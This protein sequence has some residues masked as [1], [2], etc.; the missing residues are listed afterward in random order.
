MDDLATFVGGSMSDADRSSGA[1]ASNRLGRDEFAALFQNAYGRLWLIA[2]AIVGDRSG[3]DD[4]VQESALAA[5]EKLQHFQPGTNF[6]A[7]LAR[8]VRW[9]AFNHAR[10]QAGRNTHP[11]DPHQLDLSLVDGRAEPVDLESDAAGHIPEYQTH[12]DDEVVNALRAIGETGRACILLRT[13]HQLSYRE[14]AELLEIPE[15][16]AMSHVH[17]ARQSMRDRLKNYMVTQPRSSP[18]P[19]DL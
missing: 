3:A 2:A 8:F 17:R 19:A 12:F 11:A 9:H 15:G 13:V 1:D 14:I 4:I 18:D 16:T 10:K 5:L 7:W 6:N